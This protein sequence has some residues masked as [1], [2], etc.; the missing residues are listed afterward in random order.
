MFEAH[1]FPSPLSL[2][3]SFHSV[4]DKKF[5]E[6][7]RARKPAEVELDELLSELVHGD[8]GRRD[9]S[10]AFYQLLVLTSLDVIRVEQDVDFGDITI[11]KGAKFTVKFSSSQMFSDSQS[12]QA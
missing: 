9:R 10:L 1:A 4:L 8:P 11:R 2:L 5:G 3:F 7:A 6:L 12:Q